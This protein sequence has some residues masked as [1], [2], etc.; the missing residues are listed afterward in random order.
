MTHAFVYKQEKQINKLAQ[1]LEHKNWSNFTNYVSQCLGAHIHIYIISNHVY[2]YLHIYSVH[3]KILS[4][5]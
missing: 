2:R 3:L 4:Y 5:N 1:L